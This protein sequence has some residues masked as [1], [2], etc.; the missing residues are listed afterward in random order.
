MFTDLKIPAGRRPLTRLESRIAAIAGALFAGMILVAVFE[1]FSAQRLSLVFI[2]LF[3]VPL[4]VLHELGHALVARLL[5]WQVREIVIGFGREVWRRQCGETLLRIKLVPLEGYVV[6]A[7]ADAR[8]LRWKSSLI[9]AAGPGVELL[10]LVAILGVFGPDQVF[11]DAS[12][13]GEVAL[14]SLAIAILLGAGFNLLPFRTDGGVS[15]GLGMLSSPFLSEDS[16]QCRLL[17]FELRRMQEL[18]DAGETATALQLSV[19]CLKRF[20][21]NPALRLAHAAALV[22]HRQTD[23]A[24]DYVR[25]Q[26][27]DANLQPAARRAWLRAQAQIELDAEQPSWLVLDLALQ[28]ALA[29]APQAAGL[30]ALKG[31]A[32]VLR[33]R[34]DDGGRLLAHAWRSNDGSASDAEMLAYLTIAAH[35]LGESAAAEHFRTSFAAVN[36]SRQLAE[37]VASLVKN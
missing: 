32:L 11:G 4:L 8:Q 30:L 1:E 12:G 31:A 23:A 24:R 13:A 5:G 20:P 21:D 34:H 14:Q 25:E 6:P 15:D 28:K 26:L 16:I 7:P 9:Y 27:A 10:L 2:L 36:R 35:R 29:D 22:S 18:Q 37:R 17:S 19:Q 33:G 3:W